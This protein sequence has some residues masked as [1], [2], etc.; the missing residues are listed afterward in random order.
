MTLTQVAQYTRRTVAA[1]VFLVIA[2]FVGRIGWNVGYAVYRHFVP[3]KAPPPE[4]RFGKIVGPQI[5][6]ITLGG[7]NLDYVLDTPTGKLDPLPTQLPVFPPKKA[8]RTPFSSQKA[9][10]LAREL[11][12]NGAP[13]VVSPSTY[14]WSEGVRSLEMNIISRDFTVTS[15][16]HVLDARLA[17]GS[18]PSPERAEALAIDYLSSLGLVDKSTESLKKTTTLLKVERGKLEKAESASEAELTRVDLFKTVAIGDQTYQI[19]GQNPV[20]ANTYL[21]ISNERTK[22]DKYPEVHYESGNLKEDEGS[23][24]PLLTVDEAW[25]RISEGKGYLV[26]LQPPEVGSSDQAERAQIKKLRVQKAYLAYYQDAEPRDYITPIFVFEGLAEAPRGRLWNFIT[27]LP[28]IPDSWLK[29]PRE[30]EPPK[31]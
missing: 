29:A 23:T 27:Y 14:R 20:E 18:A 16:L 1:A 12:F 5:K 13:E 25:K 8:L 24:Y 15:D 30:S 22:A 9:T 4:V 17:P 6:G 11:G 2:L 3:P 26:Y 19:L 7:G 28:A 21:L 10:E 31:E